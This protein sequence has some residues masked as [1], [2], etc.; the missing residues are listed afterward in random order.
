MLTVHVIA[1]AAAAAARELRGIYVLLGQQYIRTYR[2]PLE[3][4]SRLVA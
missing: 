1:A 2:N 4:V 3:G